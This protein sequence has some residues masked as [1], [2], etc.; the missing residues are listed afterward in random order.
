[1][2]RARTYTLEEIVGWFAEAG[3]PE[4]EVHRNERSP[5]RIVVVA[6]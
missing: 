4:P 5:W 3:L 2:S 6:R 1:M